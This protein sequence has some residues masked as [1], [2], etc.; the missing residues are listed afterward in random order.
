MLRHYQLEGRRRK[1]ATGVDLLDK[2]NACVALAMDKRCRAALPVGI[3]LLNAFNTKT[4]RCD[5]SISRIARELDI[6]ER[7]VHR[8][9]N[10]LKAC[11][12][13]DWKRHGG[14]HLTN[15]YSFNWAALTAAAEV[16]CESEGET[17]R[18]HPPDKS[19]TPPLTNLSETPDSG[20]TQNLKQTFNETLNKPTSQKEAWQKKEVDGKTEHTHQ[21]PQRELPVLSVVGGSN[22]ST[23]PTKVKHTRKFDTP[24]T[25]DVWERKARERV[26]KVLSANS[27]WVVAMENSG[28][29]EAAIL[30]EQNK[31]GA[32][33]QAFNAALEQSTEDPGKV[34]LCL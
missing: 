2:H 4:G 13:L 20:V 30:A 12:W 1:T 7:T 23:I 14:N 11:G 34:A 25:T 19:V 28:A 16:Q 26:Q 5:W 32:C 21:P 22:T 15:A 31:P 27:L 17:K 18:V 24:D 8:A 9:I 10:K 33:L 29:F 6:T 3:F